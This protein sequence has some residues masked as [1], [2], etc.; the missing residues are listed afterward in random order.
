LCSGNNRAREIEVEDADEIGGVVIASLERGGGGDGG[1]DGVKEGE[2]PRE[3]PS[4]S[5]LR[6]FNGVPIKSK[7]RRSTFFAPKIKKIVDDSAACVLCFLIST[8]RAKWKTV[9]LRHQLIGEAGILS[10]CKAAESKESCLVCMDVRCNPAGADLR[11]GNVERGAESVALR[12]LAMLAERMRERFNVGK[13]GLEELC[14]VT[15]KNHVETTTTMT[16][17][18]T[19]KESVSELGLQP[20]LKS[21]L[22]GGGSGKF[23]KL[24]RGMSVQNLI[25]KGK[26]GRSASSSSA[27]EAKRMVYLRNRSN[28][29]V[30][31]GGQSGRNHSGAGGTGGGAGGEAG[32]R[33][34]GGRGGGSGDGVGDN[35]RDGLS[36]GDEY[37]RWAFGEFERDD[38]LSALVQNV[39]VE[40]WSEEEDEEDQSD[41]LTST[42]ELVL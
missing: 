5:S 19:D 14:G 8:G 13:D 24:R 28:A 17:T 18:T 10:L 42:K 38:D 11:N 36:D 2:G 32:S 15:L 34:G 6:W 25:A 26:H 33:P 23:S 16:T 9:D 21:V 3:S 31:Y 29:V 37:E 27:S 40:G 20:W 7:A 30:S 41:L 35:A 12:R 4:T 1:E 22:A 39:E